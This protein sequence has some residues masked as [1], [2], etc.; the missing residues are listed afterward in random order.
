MI[1]LALFFLN[2][3]L[4]KVGMGMGVELE[5]RVGMGMGIGL[6]TR[7]YIKRKES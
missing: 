3:L 5:V 4:S 7:V 6:G 1:P 2:L